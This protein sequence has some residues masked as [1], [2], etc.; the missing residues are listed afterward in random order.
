M[1]DVQS[2]SIFDRLFSISP[3]MP[4]QYRVMLCAQCDNE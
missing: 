2:P 3:A 4:K 1:K